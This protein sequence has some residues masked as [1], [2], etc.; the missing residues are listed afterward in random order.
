MNYQKGIINVI[1]LVIIVVL[2]G[3]V[4]Y[5]YAKDK[6]PA[7]VVLPE[8]KQEVVNTPP[9][10]KTIAKENTFRSAKYG[11][12]FQYPSQWPK[13]E[14]ITAYGKTYV[15]L[16]VDV[17]PA[18][19]RDAVIEVY[20]STT[21]DFVLK[22]NQFTKGKSVSYEKGWAIIRESSDNTQALIQHKENVY[23]IS[24]PSS[25]V[26]QVSRTFTFKD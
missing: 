25:V 10:S 19:D 3:L 7:T 2:A 8:P 14:E 20:Q 21:L 23:H 1:L 5:F 15:N 11:Y 9:K 24:G 16:Y 4:G 13:V 17:Y 12:S 22:N 26:E 18:Q 6:T